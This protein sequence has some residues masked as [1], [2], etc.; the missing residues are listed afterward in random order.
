MIGY[1]WVIAALAVV[2]AYDSV[3]E[4]LLHKTVD[5]VWIGG[6]NRVT[7]WFVRRIVVI[8]RGRTVYLRFGYV[9]VLHKT[10]YTRE[11]A[12]EHAVAVVGDLAEY[13]K[14]DVITYYTVD[15]K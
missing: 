6:G 8:V 7:K 1:T 11:R 9:T 4:A 5:G 12:H 14:D 13:V 10:L 3:V 2:A 15:K